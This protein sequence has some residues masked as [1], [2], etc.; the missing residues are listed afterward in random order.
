MIEDSISS[1]TNKI[2][3]ISVIDFGKSS[4]FPPHMSAIDFLSD[5]RNAVKRAFS[6]VQY[7]SATV[8]IDP[9]FNSTIDPDVFYHMLMLN[10]IWSFGMLIYEMVIGNVYYNYKGPAI[11]VISC[12]IRDMGRYIRPDTPIPLTETDMSKFDTDI[13][14]ILNHSCTY[15]PRRLS[16]SD[17]DFVK[18]AKQEIQMLDEMVSCL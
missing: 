7:V 1:G 14:V 18:Y 12:M 8:F 15:R 9:D 10:D 13:L 5:R 11:S 4:Y 17:A 16:I 2:G 6:T 3:K